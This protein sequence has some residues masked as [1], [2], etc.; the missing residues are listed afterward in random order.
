MLMLV[1][2][3]LEL[4]FVPNMVRLMPRGS[5][6][7][8][9]RYT[10]IPGA[11]SGTA[12]SYVVNID[13]WHARGIR[14]V[15]AT[16]RNTIGDVAKVNGSRRFYVRVGSAVDWA[17]NAIFVSGLHGNPAWCWSGRAVVGLIFHT[18]E[19]R[20]PKSSIARSCGFVAV[21][22]ADGRLES[23]PGFV[24]EGSGSSSSSSRCSSSRCSSSRCRKDEEDEA[25]HILHLLC[26]KRY[27][28]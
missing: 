26:I 11:N 17:R 23:K 10:Y 15:G 9:H 5:G 16:K 14:P 7:V 24:S 21:I 13:Y 19:N 18:T 1:T 28:M 25:P 27:D 4:L 8:A 3:T 6:Q 12:V 20:P 2:A 22:G